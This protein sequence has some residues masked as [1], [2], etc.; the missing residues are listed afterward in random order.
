MFELALI[1]HIDYRNYYDIPSS[2]VLSQEYVHDKTLYLAHYDSFGPDEHAAT[3]VEK[4]RSYVYLAIIAD[5][6][7]AGGDLAF[8]KDIHNSETFKFVEQ[9][10]VEAYARWNKE[11]FTK[12]RVLPKKED[13]DYIWVDN[14]HSSRS[15]RLGK[16]TEMVKLLAKGKVVKVKRPNFHQIDAERFLGHYPMLEILNS[17]KCG[18]MYLED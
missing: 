8:L 4:V 14:G 10:A 11:R 17:F 18:L 7:T 15:W 13:A 2:K 5:G 9:Q 6:L 12:I 1:N 3:F 16:S